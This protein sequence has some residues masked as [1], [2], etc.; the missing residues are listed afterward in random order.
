M[1][2]VGFIFLINKQIPL[3]SER[4]YEGKILL[5]SLSIIETYN[6]NNKQRG[7]FLKNQNIPKRYNYKEI[8]NLVSDEWGIEAKYIENINPIPQKLKKNIIY[9]VLLKNTFLK[10]LAKLKSTIEF[11]S[12]LKI[13]KESILLSYNLDSL[14]KDGFDL[15]TSISKFNENRLNEVR[16]TPIFNSELQ[17]VKTISLNDLVN[18]LIGLF[19]LQDGI[20]NFI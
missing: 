7:I 13:F 2:N 4:N 5:N 6:E 19:P 11:V 8:T 18:G 20:K 3:K 10:K 15:F 17:I 16:K 14:D 12:G 1:P 9:C